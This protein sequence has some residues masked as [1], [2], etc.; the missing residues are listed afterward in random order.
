MCQL[1]KNPSSCNIIGIRRA[2][3]GL[4]VSV[5]KVS[6]VA[7]SLLGW[8][9]Q[10]LLKTRFGTWKEVT[11]IHAWIDHEHLATTWDGHCVSVCVEDVS[12]DREIS[13]D[14]VIFVLCPACH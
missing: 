13:P 6:K 5:R 14:I 7:L 12:D 2:A 4:T 1:G 9:N 8:P 11:Y 10:Q 3:L